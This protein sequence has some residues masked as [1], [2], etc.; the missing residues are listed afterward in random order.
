MAAK[1]RVQDRQSKTPTS[2]LCIIGNYLH[3]VLSKGINKSDEWYLPMFTDANRVKLVPYASIL[4]AIKLCNI[5][6]DMYYSFAVC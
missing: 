3:K 1:A 2:F 4:Y 6:I 5:F